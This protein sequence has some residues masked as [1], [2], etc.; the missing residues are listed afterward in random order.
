MADKM[1][2]N[3]LD[4]IFTDS[5]SQIDHS[6]IAAVL[7]PFLR[8][9][10]ENNRVLFTPTGMKITANNKI[11]LVILVQKV[12]H[13][14]GIIDTESVTPKEIKEELRDIPA[15]TI[16]A[17]LKHLSERGPL[18]GQDG[19]YFIPDFNFPQVQEIFNKLEV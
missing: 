5:Q 9:N 7:K 13:M 18:K 11:I 15:G 4:E 1:T 12:L 8:I 19:R 3:P 2:P 17:A 16:D 6:S 10:R 14:Q